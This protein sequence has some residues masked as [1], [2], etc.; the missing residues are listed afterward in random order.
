MNEEASLI[1]K[2]NK[3]D[4]EHLNVKIK[5]NFW[6]ISFV[7][8]SLI[9]FFILKVSF[10]FV[11]TFYI[12]F[13]WNWLLASKG[14]RRRGKRRKYKF[15]FVRFALILNKV[16]ERVVAINHPGRKKLTRT[17]SPLFFFFLVFAVSGEFFIVS[18]LLG[19]VYFEWVRR[20]AQ[21]LSEVS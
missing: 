17:L 13:Y 16:F 10:W 9:L 15:S 8:A 4:I 11:V 2:L 7:L 12:A 6:L 14:I 19:S 21:Q 18:S 5:N 20:F 1:E 3:L